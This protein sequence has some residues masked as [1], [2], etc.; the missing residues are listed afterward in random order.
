MSCPGHA[1]ARLLIQAAA[2]R[3]QGDN[4]QEAGGIAPVRGK[5]MVMKI[6]RGYY[7]TPQ[8]EIFLAKHLVKLGGS[9][10]LILNR[11]WARIF[12]PE[13]WVELEIHTHTG[14]ITIRPL[15]REK[16]EVINDQR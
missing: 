3:K 11:R 5:D 6:P 4:G 16:Q 15:S 7:V 1:L 8:A 12:A 10:A 13:D 2:A 9:K 14:A